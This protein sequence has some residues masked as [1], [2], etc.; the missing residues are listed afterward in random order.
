VMGLGGLVAVIG[1]TLFLV[2][3][4]GAVLRRR[5]ARAPAHG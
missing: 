5:G 4:F 2:L 3:A 1:G